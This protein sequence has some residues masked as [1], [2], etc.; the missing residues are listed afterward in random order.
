MS[1][2]RSKKSETLEVRL[3]HEVKTALMRKAQQEGRSTSDVVREFIDAYLAEKPKE[4]RSMI[5]ALWKP[6]TAIGAASF[7]ALVAVVAPTQLHA[8]PDLGA[9]FKSL[10]RDGS[11]SLTIAEFQQLSSSAEVQKAH[12]AHAAAARD[13]KGGDHGIAEHAA[14]AASSPERMQAHFKKLD[15]NS[16]GA[17]TLAEIEQHHRHMEQSHKTR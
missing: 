2:R 15:S 9:I 16:D 14:H 10:D 8:K 17:V 6:A 11:G 4:A 12:D 7:A 13:G 5:F 3:E 1:T